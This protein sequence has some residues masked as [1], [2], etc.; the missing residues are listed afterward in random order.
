MAPRLQ[1]SQL[2]DGQHPYRAEVPSI[3]NATGN[4]EKYAEFRRGIRGGQG[5]VSELEKEQ[6]G[7]RAEGR[8]GRSLVPLLLAR[9]PSR[10]GVIGLGLR[11]WSPPGYRRRSY[12]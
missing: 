1:H 5:I 3:T 10:R 9:V 11:P 6:L 7:H 8:W 2:L 4:S 12:S